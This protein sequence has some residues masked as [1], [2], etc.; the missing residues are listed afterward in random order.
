MKSLMRLLGKMLADASVWCSTSTTRDLET[1][2]RRVK[3]EGISFLMITLPTYSEDFERSLREGRI[4]S[5]SF[6]SFKKRGA[7]PLF[8]G[9]LL[10]QVF[11]PVS[12][13]LLDTPST[14]AI[15]FVRQICLMSKKISYE[16]TDAR[17]ANA[18]ARYVETNESCREWERIHQSELCSIVGADLLLSPVGPVS[19]FSPELASFRE[20]AGMLWSGILRDEIFSP[21]NLVPKHGP[22]ATAE[23]II[24]NDKYAIQHWHL[25]QEE[26]FPSDLF[27][28]PNWDYSDLLG[29]VTYLTPEQELP[30]RVIHVPKTL[31]TPRIIAIEPVCVQ[32]AQQAV[33]EK[34]VPILENHESLHGSLGFT[35]QTVN[36]KLALSSSSD[37]RL[38]TIDLKDASDR[39][40]SQL[41]YAM[42]E[43]AP[44]FREC[45]FSCR[46]I[47]ADVPGYGIQSLAR[48]AS[49]GSALCFPIEAMVFYTIILSSIARS[50]GHRL[51][52]SLLREITKSVRIYGDDI[53][54]PV[55]YVHIVT[56]ELEWFNLRVNAS[57]TFGT[58]KFRE[59]C[60]MDAFDGTPVTPVYLRKML[61]TSRLQTGEVI[62]TISFRNQLYEAGCWETVAFLDSLLERL[63][64][65]PQVSKESSLQGRHSFLKSEEKGRWDPNLH[66]YLVKGIVVKSVKRPSVLDG[67]FALMKWFLKRG[68]KPFEDKNHLQFGG[69]PLSV[70]TK[71]KWALP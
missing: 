34:L 33:M 6:L 30:V 10:R 17:V 22:G 50:K 29:D 12:G 36:Q 59:S 61:P 43:S 25:R 8:L 4:A 1:V 65:F 28:I 16:C 45:V 11:D 68:D 54:I 48:F 14:S 60:G 3:H 38:A 26:C 23:H 13:V 2:S 71:T 51:T 58:G 31:K 46:S 15:W 9:G 24:G 27:I 39:V 67:P 66:H 19:S 18:F 70:Y 49:M 56:N 44:H 21:E 55:E 63:I 69:R 37:G 41:V 40:S 47:R 62:S 32:Y 35:D 64:P 5:N 7:L 42:L 52:P 20:V 57:K 53:I